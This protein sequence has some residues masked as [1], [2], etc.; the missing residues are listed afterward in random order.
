ML[1]EGVKLGSS[2]VFMKLVMK[3]LSQKNRRN[4]GQTD[5]PGLLARFR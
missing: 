1:S 4:H 3:P 2:C 5:V